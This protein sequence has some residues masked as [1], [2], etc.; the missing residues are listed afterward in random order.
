MC[1]PPPKPPMCPP[2]PP[3]CANPPPPK[4]PM[5]PN[6]PAAEA[7]HMS[8]PSGESVASIEAVPA[9]EAVA[10]TVTVAAVAVVARVAVAE[11][12]VA[13]VRPVIAVVRAGAIGISVGAIAAVIG[14]GGGRARS[15]DAADHARGG[16]GAGVVAVSIDVAIPASVRVVMRMAVR[17][18]PINRMRAVM[19]HG[20]RIGRAE[21]RR[22]QDGSAEGKDWKSKRGQRHGELLA[23]LRGPNPQGAPL[24]LVNSLAQP[25]ASIKSIDRLTFLYSYI[26]P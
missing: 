22:H 24:C 16:Y 26:S 3:P 6:P 8:E 18:M 2:K 20:R 5:W 12:V 1:A 23:I 21:R 7:A 10:T 17:G 15:E 13:V 25:I 19:N 14:I 4:P 11:A 9:V